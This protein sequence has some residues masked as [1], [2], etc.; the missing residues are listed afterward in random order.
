[1]AEAAENVV[2]VEPEMTR[3]ALRLVQHYNL[4]FYDAV[5]VAAALKAECTTY[6][7]EDLQHGL[8][9]DHKLTIQNP[10]L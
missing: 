8:I 2:A 10:F 5:M 9:V 4:A 1:M 3:T 7:S 6:Y